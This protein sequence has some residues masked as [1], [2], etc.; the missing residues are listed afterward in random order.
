MINPIY[1][2]IISFILPGTGQILQGETRFGIILLVI[3]II[4][5]IIIFYAHLGFMGSLLSFIY[6][7]Y[8]AYDAYKINVQ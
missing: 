8:A 4:L 5:G 2:A 6:S 1:V 3:A 7:I